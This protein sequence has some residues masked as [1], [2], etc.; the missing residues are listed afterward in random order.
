M[1]Y[2]WSKSCNS[3]VPFT[4]SVLFHF[5]NKAENLIGEREVKKVTCSMV[6]KVKKFHRE[7]LIFLI[8]LMGLIP[9]HTNF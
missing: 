9:Y 1:R 8:K 2:E 5:I 7:S 4:I 6:L 3:N